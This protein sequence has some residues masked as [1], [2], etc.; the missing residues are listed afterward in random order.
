MKSA[1][2][3]KIIFLSLLFFSQ[4]P[5][6]TKGSE[7]NTPGVHFRPITLEEAIEAAKAENKKVF[8]HGFADWCHFCM[9]MKDSVYIDK[10]VGDFYNANFVCI[11]L[12]MEKEGKELNK[13][14]RS[15]TFPTFL[16]YD[17]NGELMHRAAGRRYKQP[18][19]ELGKEALDPKRQM[20]TFRNKYDS[21]T[22]TPYEVQFY[23]RM[24][25][26]AG[27]DAQLLIDD[28]LSKQPDSEFTNANN[29]RI[30]FDILKDPTLPVMK[31]ILENKK[32]I[33]KKYTADSINNR[34]ISMYNN[35]LTGYVQRVDSAGFESAKRQ[36]LNTPNLD[37]AEK[38]VAW[39]DLN[40]LKMKS[41][42]ETYK[43][44]GKK[45]IDKYAM[46]DFKRLNDV[47]QNYY[48]RFYT[49]K[50]AMAQAEQ[51]MLKSVTLADIYKANHLLASICFVLGKKEQ[52]LKYANHAIELAKATNTDS[53]QTAVLLEKIQEMP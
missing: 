38:I 30:M 47:S 40:K 52:A 10:E 8:V 36:V 29:W 46:N 26:I 45:F 13:T 1:S 31:R 50:E 43:A 18:F 16:F 27:M 11:K 3:L 53:K 24:M 28:Y 37:I 49:D 41:E 39:A 32:E 14:I 2:H 12:D 15:H 35:Y 6:I 25:E 34:L 7:D 21:G 42:W 22:A 4:L 9:Y 23:F 44:E 17:T 5:Q 19:I 51:W 48:D 33:E 20:R